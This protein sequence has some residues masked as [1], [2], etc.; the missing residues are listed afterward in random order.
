[1]HATNEAT[2]VTS[3]RAQCSVKAGQGWSR[4]VNGKKIHEVVPVSPSPCLPPSKA[5]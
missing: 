3:I 5:G 1:M 4:L 2:T